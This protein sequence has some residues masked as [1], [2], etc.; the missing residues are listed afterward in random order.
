MKLAKQLFKACLVVV[1]EI[2]NRLCI[3]K[4]NWLHL[5]WQT[6]RA[7]RVCEC[8]CTPFNEIQTSRKRH[9][10]HMNTLHM[11]T[12]PS[13]FVIWI[14]KS[15]TTYKRSHNHSWNLRCVSLS[16]KVNCYKYHC[17]T[18][19]RR[20]RQRQ[21]E[22]DSQVDTT[23]VHLFTRVKLITLRIERYSYKMTEN[24]KEVLIIS[25]LFT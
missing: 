11:N 2:F 25:I 10:A 8:T 23:A 18:E 1:K 14:V 19:G 4:F 6:L 16:G 12:L 22:H 13:D 17:E 9:K 3:F 15:V 7:Q 21:W 24:R 5:R 20:K